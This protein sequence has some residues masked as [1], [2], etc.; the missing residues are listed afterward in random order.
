MPN[1]L[2]SEWSRT[3]QN[4]PEYLW[5]FKEILTPRQS[6]LDHKYI[7]AYSYLPTYI[8]HGME[9]ILTSAA[10][11]VNKQYYERNTYISS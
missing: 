11:F 3:G 1:R 4:W 2:Q 8:T 9:E 6:G 5:A 7:S 10:K